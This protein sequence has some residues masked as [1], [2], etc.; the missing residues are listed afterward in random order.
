M[1]KSSKFF[2]LIIFPSYVGRTYGP[3][4]LLIRKDQGGRSFLFKDESKSSIGSP[5]LR[6]FCLK[7]YVGHIFFSASC[8]ADQRVSPF[9]NPFI[10]ERL[11]FIFYFYFYLKDLFCFLLFLLCR[12]PSDEAL[13]MLLTSKGGQLKV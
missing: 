12:C 9:G 11:Y 10:Y 4:S 8:D 3:P 1:K 6:F 2:I 5:N 13:F 7:F